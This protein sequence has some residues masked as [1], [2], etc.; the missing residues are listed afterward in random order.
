M[1]NKHLGN[2]WF[3]RVGESARQRMRVDPQ[4]IGNDIGSVERE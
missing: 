2:T 4:G 1:A 3:T